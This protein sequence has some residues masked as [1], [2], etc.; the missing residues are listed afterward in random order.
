MNVINESFGEQ[1][2]MKIVDFAM[3]K[4]LIAERKFENFVKELYKYR[5]SLVHA[6]EKQILNTHVPNPFERNTQEDIWNNILEDISVKVIRR[7]NKTN[8]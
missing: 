7:F 8:G 3:E 4:N 5:N 1:N 2:K 6:K